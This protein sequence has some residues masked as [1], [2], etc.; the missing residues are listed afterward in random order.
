MAQSRVL[1]LL[2][3]PGHPPPPPPTVISSH[4][5]AQN[6]IYSKHSAFH[7]LPVLSASF[8]AD[9]ESDTSHL[10]CYCPDPTPHISWGDQRNSFLTLL[11]CISVP[12]MVFSPHRGQKD[13]FSETRQILLSTQS[14]NAFPSPL[15]PQFTLA[16]KNSWTPWIQISNLSPP[17]ATL[18]P[19]YSSSGPSI[20]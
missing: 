14:S 12:F 2:S 13:S 16:Y 5:K 6:I 10:A 8:K 20:P 15:K 1:R 3:S 4:L 19:S 7:T 11:S 9:L 18:T 17:P